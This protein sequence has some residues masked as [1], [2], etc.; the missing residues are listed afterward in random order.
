[1]VS[2]PFDVQPVQGELIAKRHQRKANE[3]LQEPDIPRRIE[4]PDDIFEVDAIIEFCYEGDYGRRWF[5]PELFYHVCIFDIAEKYGLFRLKELA[6]DKLK[7]ALSTVY[8]GADLATTAKHLYLTEEHELREV[9]VQA[10]YARRAELLS[11]GSA[12]REALLNIPE[13]ARDMVIRNVDGINGEGSNVAPR[14][15]RN[16][17]PSVATPDQSKGGE[18]G[19]NSRVSQ[20]DAALGRV[21]AMRESKEPEQ[22]YDPGIGGADGEAETLALPQR[23]KQTK[24]KRSESSAAS[25]R[26][27]ATEGCARTE[28]V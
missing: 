2:Y 8:T 26:Y 12:T 5:G 14:D 9:F 11:R 18:T 4:L 28:S 24:R 6:R 3:A 25:E 15:P 19:S 20:T 21:E 27:E 17:R 23:F 10:I 1:M 16:G 13:L 7:A 22:S